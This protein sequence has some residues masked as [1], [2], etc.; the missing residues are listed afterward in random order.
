MLSVETTDVIVSESSSRGNQTKFYRD[1]CWVKLDN[2]IEGMA[3]EFSSF[4]AD[5]ILDFPHVQYRSV[6][7]LSS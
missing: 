1:G 3:E 6:E 2:H 5:C 7:V 4:L